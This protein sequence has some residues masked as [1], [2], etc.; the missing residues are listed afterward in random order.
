MEEIASGKREV[1]ELGV[2]GGQKIISFNKNLVQLFYSWAAYIY[3][4]VKE[5]KNQCELKI[6]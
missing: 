2:E 5:N 4:W 6:D 1:M 3:D